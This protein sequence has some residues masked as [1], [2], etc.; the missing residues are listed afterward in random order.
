MKAYVEKVN[1]EVRCTAGWPVPVT[2]CTTTM[3]TEDGKHIEV[4][5]IFGRDAVY[6]V[7]I[8]VKRVRTHAPKGYRW[9]RDT[10][11]DDHGRW[12]ETTHA[13]R[14]SPAVVGHHDNSLIGVPRV[15]FEAFVSEGLL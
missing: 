11:I 1:R 10:L 15:V 13:G 6:D 3:L 8:T 9:E 4:D 14:T 2:H 7:E 5:G 12:Y